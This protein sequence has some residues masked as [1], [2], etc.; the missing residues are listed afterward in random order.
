MKIKPKVSVI[1]PVYNTESYVREAVESIMHQ[2]LHEIEII[3]VDDGSTDKSTFVLQELML[4]DNRIQ[5]YTQKNQ[6]QSIARNNGINF[7]KGQYLYFMDSDDLLE[8]DTLLSC[9]EKCEFDHLDFVFFDAKVLNECS[10]TVFSMDYHHWN[11]E[12][13][14]YKGLE[15]ID[16]LIDTNQLK[17]PPY[18]VFISRQYM[19]NIHLNFYPNIIHEDQLFTVLL[20]IN[21]LRVGYIPKEFFQRRIR[22]NSTMTKPISWINVVGYFTVFKELRIYG[23]T[24][25]KEVRHIIKKYLSITINAFVHNA[26]EMSFFEKFKMCKLCVKEGWVRHIHLKNA[27]RFLFP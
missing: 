24:K 21:A 10:S 9:Y 3:I 27:I 18:L 14:V 13:R 12:D 6:G 22:K 19:E 26:H 1:I 7:A 15:I 20:Y 2:T 8:K 16:F 11:I 17:I 25:N 5:I 23:K 4:Q